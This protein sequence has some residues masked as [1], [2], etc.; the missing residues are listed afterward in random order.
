VDIDNKIKELKDNFNSD[1]LLIKSS[2]IDYN[3]V[4]T[5][6]FGRKGLING[7]Y[8]YLGKVNNKDKPL[9]GNKINNLKKELL[10]Q[11]EIFNKD[12]SSKNIKQE[13]DVSLPEIS[14]NFGSIH[15]LTSVINEIKDIF[16][17]I[18]FSSIYGPEVD[19]EYYNFEALNIP[20]HHPARDMQDTFY[21]DDE[22]LLR[23]HT[24]GSQIHFMEKNNPPIRII[25][26]GRV[27]RNEDISVRSYCLFHQ[28]EGLYIDKKVTLSD[29]KG[30]LNYFAKELFG[31]NVKTR[32]RPSFFPFTEPSAEMDVYWGLNN[33]SDYRITKGT[34]WL[35][36][37]GCGMVDPE[38]FKS[39]NYDPDVWK[40]F[41]FGLGIERMAMLLY[42]I[43]DIRKFYEGDIRFLRQF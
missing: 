36:I 13:F 27:Y 43:D 30:T 21:I 26:P 24:S 35:E 40:G 3:Q 37:L 28:I 11:I 5:K 14:R 18:G 10:D 42:G 38:V 22:L 31:K 19:T 23:T 41:A 1:I 16:N 33:E 34:G 12:N 39:V 4:Y 32:F 17:K 15:P 9:I 25:S 7:L 8:L 29:L 20:E 6:Y 2:K